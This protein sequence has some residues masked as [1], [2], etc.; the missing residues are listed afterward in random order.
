MLVDFHTHILPNFDDGSKSVEESIQMLTLESEQGI[1][2][3]VLTPHFYPTE[4]DPKTYLERRKRAYETLVLEASK[5]EGLPTL[6]LGAEVYYFD[7]IGKW[8]GLKDLTIENT[9][10]VLIEMPLAPWTNRMYKE[11]EDIAH[12]LGLI[13]IIAHMDRY[14]APF[15][16]H[17]I[18]NKLAKLPVL[19]QVNSSFFL[20]PKTSFM[21]FKLLKDG[22]IQL[23]GSDCHNME[24]RLPNM[25]V[26]INKIVS[27]L[28]L[29]MIENINAYEKQILKYIRGGN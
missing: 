1:K 4:D 22:K 11:L 27:K 6:Y 29:E 12:N 13:P 24:Y 19:V 8:E 5:Y 20:K 23:V 26:T 28:G 7:G 17:D 2:E 18:P 14:I 10:Y 21:A 15:K 9:N 25:Q 16:T 3:V